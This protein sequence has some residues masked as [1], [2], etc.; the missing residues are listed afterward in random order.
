MSPKQIDTEKLAKRICSKKLVSSLIQ[1]KF[2]IELETVFYNSPQT[3]N[4]KLA[5]VY[6]FFLYCLLMYAIADSVHIGSFMTD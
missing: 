1:T 2:F 3:Y 4:D 5:C 6:I